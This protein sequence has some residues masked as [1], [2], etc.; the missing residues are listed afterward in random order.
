M[1]YRVITATAALS[2]LLGGAM[3][4][5]AAVTITVNKSTQ[6]MTVSVNGEP[7]YHWPVSTARWGYRTPNGTYGPERLAR[8]WYSRK[9]H[10]SPMPYSIFFSGGYAIH[11]SYEVSHIG[12]P[13]SHGCIRLYPRNAAT[14]F[15]LVQENRGNTRIVVTGSKASPRLY[16]RS[17]VER[18]RPRRYRRYHAESRYRAE[19]YDDAYNQAPGRYDGPPPLPFFFAPPPR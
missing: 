16:A 11:G 17:R 1:L 9:Y 6:R 10:N 13:A 2:F 7:R 18:E 5:Q 12:R 4:A 3:A 14:L 19:S 8:H 15:R